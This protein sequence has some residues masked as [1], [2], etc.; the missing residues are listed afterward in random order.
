MKCRRRS[1]ELSSLPFTVTSTT[2][3]LDLYISSNSRNL[4]QF[5]V[6]EK[7]GK[8]NRKPYAFPNGLRN[9]HRNL[10]SE[11]TQDYAQKPQRNCTFMNSASGRG[12]LG[13]L[14][15]T[16]RNCASLSRK[17]YFFRS[18]YA[19]GIG[20]RDNP[21]CRRPNFTVER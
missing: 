17:I 9:P 12:Q 21:R 6:K 7:G 18:S 10:K 8:P 4:L 13:L 11:N 2:L 1:S 16:S 3:P 19:P 20:K 14:H 5:Q 15:S